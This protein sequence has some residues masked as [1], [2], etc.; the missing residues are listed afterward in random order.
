M[1]LCVQGDARV[2]QEDRVSGQAVGSVQG[3]HGVAALDAQRQLGPKRARGGDARD[4]AVDDGAPSRPV[5]VRHARAVGPHLRRSG[6]RRHHAARPHRG[7]PRRLPRSHVQAVGSGV[8]DVRGRRR[9][10]HRVLSHRRVRLPRDAALHAPQPAQQLPVGAGARGR[11][12]QPVLRERAGVPR[13]R[14]AVQGGVLALLAAEGRVVQPAQPPHHRADG[15]QPG[16][17]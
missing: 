12:H 13:Q 16:I 9:R 7:G 10:D 15:R 11:A 1:A 6:Q 3:G 8:R 5:D 2:L 4:Q 14:D 17:L